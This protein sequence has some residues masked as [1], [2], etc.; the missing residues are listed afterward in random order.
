MRYKIDEPT[1][2]FKLNRRRAQ[3]PV[4]DNVKAAGAR[5]EYMFE[6]KPGVWYKGTITEMNNDGATAKAKF[7]DGDDSQDLL[8]WGDLKGG[9]IKILEGGEHA[10]LPSTTAL[11]RRLPP[12]A[13][14][15]IQQTIC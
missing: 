4:V 12:A 15:T 14:A 11:Q 2:N 7:D 1:I 8:V 6:N 3:A 10:Q 9:R 5:F 13:R